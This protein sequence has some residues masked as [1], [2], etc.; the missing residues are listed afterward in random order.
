MMHPAPH[1]D[2]ERLDRLRLIRSENIGPVTFRE[3]LT[4]FGSAEAALEALPTLAKRGGRKRALRVA[5]RQQATKE[6]DALVR[7]G[8]QMLHINA[9]DYPPLLATIDDAPPVLSVIGHPSLLLRDC[10]GMVGAR[11]AST[12]GKT[13]ARRFATEIGRAGPTI[14]SGL[15]MGIDAAVHDGSLDT[16]TV[17][18]LGGGVD[19]IY[20]RDNT[21]LYHE[22][23]RRGAIVSEMPF[24]TVPQARHF[25]RR[26]RII[27]GLSRAVLVVEATQ[28]SGSLITARLAADQG[29]EVMAI[30]GSP[31]D[32]RAKG[33]NKLIRGGAALVESPDDVLMLLNELPPAQLDAGPE[34][35]FEPAM[36][37]T[38]NDA[39]LTE[40]RRLVLD[41]LG[42]TPAPV[43]D[44][45]AD[46]GLPMGILATVLLELE[47]AGR[48]ERSA[49][50][51]VCAVIRDEATKESSKPVPSR[52]NRDLFDPV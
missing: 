3:L 52:G 34:T 21:A 4:R 16:G 36:P 37:S 35:G 45:A 32:P 43:D 42:P 38:P 13:L 17:A 46:L 8:G 33:P 24:G 49:G 23:S 39:E 14:V 15:A 2:A 12:N 28:R 10:V 19:V 26:N 27:S 29:R 18:V 50:N 48:L 47:L 20:P 7:H 25:P 1:N 31:M 11:N 22:I 41:R 51:R 40:A 9:T 44:L 6:L 30:P 5:T